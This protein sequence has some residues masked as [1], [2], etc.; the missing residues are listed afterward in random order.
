MY[1]GNENP[2]QLLLD[3]DINKFFGIGICEK[4]GAGAR[5]GEMCIYEFEDGLEVHCRDCEIG[6]SRKPTLAEA[7]VEWNE[8]QG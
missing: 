4:C 7:I 1:T 3:R 8:S 2:K 6:G 5:K